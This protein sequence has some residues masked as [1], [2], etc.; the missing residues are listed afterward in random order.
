MQGFDQFFIGVRLKNLHIIRFHNI[1][2]F[3]LSATTYIW[4]LLVFSLIYILNKHTYK[5]IYFHNIFSMIIN[6]DEYLVFPTNLW[7]VADGTISLVWKFGLF[8]TQKNLY[9]T[10]PWINIS[11][12]HK[13]RLKEV[14]SRVPFSRAQS[15]EV[16]WN[17][18]SHIRYFTVSCMVSNRIICFVT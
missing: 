13:V 16:I 10:T 5:N 3:F 7:E 12:I 14:D 8:L 2:F 6:K 1:V 4:Y 18:F 15:P 9:C 17:D 11:K